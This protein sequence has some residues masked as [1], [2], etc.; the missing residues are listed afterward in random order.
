[1]RLQN[2]VVLVTASTRGIGLACVKACAKEGAAVYMAARNLA[3]ARETADALNREGAR[4][5]CVFQDAEKPE[6]FS[7]MVE[8]DGH[9]TFTD[10]WH[11]ECSVPVE[12]IEGYRA[13]HGYRPEKGPQPIF[14]ASGPAFKPGAVVE[15]AH[16]IDE[17][18]TLAA[19]LGQTLPQ[20]DGRVLTELL[21]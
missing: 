14:L 4:V 12:A 21:A 18:P 11:G 2:K 19:V 7:F 8:G 3:R 20:A 9:T 15:N 17:A 16:V 10:D 5:N 13:K 1:M 6:T